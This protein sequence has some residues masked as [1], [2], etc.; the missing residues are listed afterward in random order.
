M[1]LNVE[2]NTNAVIGQRQPSNGRTTPESA[3]ETEI[4]QGA[5]AYLQ[6]KYYV[7]GLERFGLQKLKLLFT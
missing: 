4:L 3:T 5:C 1:Q 2:V 6:S 7:S